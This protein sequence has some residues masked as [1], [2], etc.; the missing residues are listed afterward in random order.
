MGVDVEVD[1]GM[2]VIG[3]NWPEKRNSLRPQDADEIVAALDSCQSQ[4][5]AIVLSGP[6][7]SF[8]AGADLAEIVGVVER[9]ADAVRA[10][11]YGSYQRL[12]LR[13][14]ESDAL[15]I[16][17]VDGPAVGLGADLALACDHRYVGDQG[18]LRQG[19]SGLQVI[20]G[21]GGAWLSR[22]RGGN[23]AAWEFLLSQERWDG[24][25]LEQHGL[26]IAVAGLAVERAR[27]SAG[28]FAALDPAAAVSY[29]SL[30][31]GAADETF[32]EHL[33][34]C[35]DLQVGFL[36]SPDFSP[37]ARRLLEGTKK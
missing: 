9:G 21:T 19:W 31:R 29:V 13:V 4:V 20:P 3:M 37:R 14:V 27:R 25:R 22:R 18:W 34:K 17:A 36:T 24:P 26:A 2:A 28:W 5:R 10:S 7:G 8:C 30:I 23:T 15:T 11:I 32:A 6:P 33:A 12:V 1:S 35:L 16:A